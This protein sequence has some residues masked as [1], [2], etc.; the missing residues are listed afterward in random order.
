MPTTY[1]V[2]PEVY[3]PCCDGEDIAITEDGYLCMD[4][5]HEWSHAAWMHSFRPTLAQLVVQ[6]LCYSCSLPLSAD[7]HT[8][9]CFPF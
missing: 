7:C 5:E 1:P 4:C 3:C 2:D 8:T 9:D 6:G